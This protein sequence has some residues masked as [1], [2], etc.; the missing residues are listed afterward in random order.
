MEHKFQYSH[1]SV[2]S[3]EP[4]LAQHI[5]LISSSQQQ[6]KKKTTTRRIR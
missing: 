5:I 1:I 2:V 6:Q 3:E 4:K